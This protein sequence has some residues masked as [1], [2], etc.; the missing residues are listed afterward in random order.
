MLQISCFIQVANFLPR[1][2]EAVVIPIC[3]SREWTFHIGVECIQASSKWQQRFR[4]FHIHA[5]GISGLSNRGLWTRNLSSA[6]R[7]FVLSGNGS[8]LEIVLEASRLKIYR[9]LTFFHPFHTLNYLDM[10][11]DSTFASC[12][13]KLSKLLRAMVRPSRCGNIW[14]PVS[15]WSF[16]RCLNMNQ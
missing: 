9:I 11:P 6:R 13:G 7:K 15:Q 5:S 3:W 4:R 14:P 16:R 1:L 12:H 8:L 10:R 2:P